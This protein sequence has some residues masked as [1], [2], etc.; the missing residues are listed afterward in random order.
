[1]R[2][3][4]FCLTAEFSQTQALPSF[5][6]TVSSMLSQ[7]LP[8]VCSIVYDSRI[9]MTFD[10]A[11]TGFTQEQMLTLCLPILGNSLD[12]VG[13]SRTFNDFSNLVHYYQQCLKALRLG[14]VEKP[15]EKVYQ[16]DGFFLDA[17]LEKIFSDNAPLESYFPNG[18]NRLV[19]HDREKGSDLVGLLRAYLE[20]D[21][22]VTKTVRRT[23]MHRNT[24]AYRLDTISRVSGLDLDDPRVRF[25]LML[26]FELM[27][28]AGK[29]AN[30]RL[31]S[32]GGLAD[33][34]DL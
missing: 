18:L 7:R 30:R 1:M 2:D 20:C 31:R 14:R 15:D 5:Q 33:N 8:D 6:A 10:L 11:A 23:Y 13:V 32:I 17:A 25:E 29:I 4:F 9:V 3:S 26:A 19:E 34:G 22:S 16:Y 24:V 12:K 28:Y 21:R 27:D